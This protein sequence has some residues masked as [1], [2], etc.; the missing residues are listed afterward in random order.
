MRIRISGPWTRSPSCLFSKPPPPKQSSKWGW[1]WQLIFKGDCLGVLWKHLF[2]R[3]KCH[4]LWNRWNKKIIIKTL[5]NNNLPQIWMVH[6]IGVLL[7]KWT[8]IAVPRNHCTEL[9]LSAWQ[10]CYAHLKET[11]LNLL[12]FSHQHTWDRASFLLSRWSHGA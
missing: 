12:G 11:P 3:E 8:G 2:G 9:I 1:T 5:K 4:C 10:F 7:Y 6:Y